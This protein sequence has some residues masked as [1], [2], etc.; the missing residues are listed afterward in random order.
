[1]HIGLLGGCAPNG[2]R[3]WQNLLRCDYRVL[4]GSPEP[5]KVGFHDLV[6]VTCGPVSKK[7]AVK[8]FWSYDYFFLELVA[9]FC[10]LEDNKMKVF[11]TRKKNHF[12][13]P[14]K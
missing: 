4:A 5:K 11:Q 14:V 1:M 2:G 3:Q 13:K 8:D 12:L 6:A 10:S 7:V 9:I